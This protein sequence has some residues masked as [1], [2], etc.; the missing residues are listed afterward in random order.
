MIASSAGRPSGHIETNRPKIKIIN[1]EHVRHV[2]IYAVHDQVKLSDIYYTPI[3]IAKYIDF[4]LQENN[5]KGERRRNN[6]QGPTL[7]HQTLRS[8]AI[9]VNTINQAQTLN[10][11]EPKNLENIK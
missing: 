5:I 9:R 4:I 2:D 1:T 11:S 6:N 3:V 7:T 8:G 10:C